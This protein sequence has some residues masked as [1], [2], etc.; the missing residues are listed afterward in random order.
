MS[1]RSERELSC[2]TNLS[3]FMATLQ[4]AGE[5]GVKQ[6]QSPTWTV[7]ARAGGALG[8]FYGDPDRIDWTMARAGQKNEVRLGA[9]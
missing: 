8:E 4:K 9:I 3:R 2:L 6:D 1:D 7:S 5:V